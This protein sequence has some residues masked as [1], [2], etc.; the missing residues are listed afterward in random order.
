MTDAAARANG[1]ADLV[2]LDGKIVTLEAS[3]PEAQAV[4][5]RDGEILAL[6]DDEDIKT[7]MGPSTQVID[8]HGKLA[9]PGFIEGHGHFMEL[10]RT[11]TE[12]DLTH[13]KTW[14]DILAQVAEAVKQAKPG[15]W[16]LGWGWHQEKWEHPPG[17]NVDGLPLH[18]SLDAVSPDN[19]VMLS[20]ASGHGVF[21]NALVLKLANITKATPDPQGG[22]I[23]HDTDGDPIG[24]LRDNAMQPAQDAYT[25]YLAK[26]T[27]AEARAAFR[28]TVHRAA[29]DAVSKG[30]TSFVDQGED[31]AVLDELKRLA[32]QGAL[33]LRLY[34]MVDASRGESLAVGLPGYDHY[35]RFDRFEQLT[36]FLPGHR[37]VGYAD[38]HYTVRGIGE[39]TSDGALGTHTAW[40]LKPY[41]D[42]PTSTG[43]NVTTPA[44]IRRIADI[45]IKDHYQVSVHAIGDRAN[46]EVLDVFQAEF[47][48]H[49]EAKD[50]RWRIEHAQHLDPTDIPRFGKLHVIASMQS[51][52]ACS[53]APYVVKRL[54]EQ[55][56]EQGAYMWRALMDS[57]AMIVNGT[58]VPV[59]DENPIPNFYCAVTRR[60]KKDGTPFFPAQVMTRDEAL[61]SY[62]SNNAYAMF[63][64][65]ELGSLKIGKR[66]DITVLSQ[67]ILTVPEG[68][69]P[70]TQVAYTIVGGKLVYTRP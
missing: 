54:G 3:Q 43:V 27:P 13:A 61:R 20:H 60:A 30:I 31:F 59:E 23:V 65:D 39:V 49:P 6:G 69:I 7:Y 62:T 67:D 63:Q 45:A 33:P 9:V 24:F 29:E 48:A 18:A 44:D 34:E 66:A 28:E 2:L 8:L 36:R 47:A 4:A 26:R 70:A 11:L 56:A 58:D 55:R 35:R 40:F 21:V 25:A 32:G 15:Q 68:D 53:D 38:D 10:G 64:E 50:L 42:L 14:D 57:G 1:P 5:V 46:R 52:H 22:E 51:I 41:D 37:I 19:P 17:P 12:L 16:I